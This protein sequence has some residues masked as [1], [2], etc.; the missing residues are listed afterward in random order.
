MN[1]AL[2]GVGKPL[3]CESLWFKL[4]LANLYEEAIV[5][6]KEKYGNVWK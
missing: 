3:K 2:A 6:K 5:I 4:N 1:K